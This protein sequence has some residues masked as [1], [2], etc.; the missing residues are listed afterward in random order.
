M[1]SIGLQT[2]LTKRTFIR[3]LKHFQTDHCGRFMKL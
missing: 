2:I 3:C 1:L